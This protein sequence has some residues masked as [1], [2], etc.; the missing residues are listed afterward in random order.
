MKLYLLRHA[1]AVDIAAT[2][3]ARALTSAG[4]EEARKVGSA[5]GKLGARL[6]HIFHSPL[7]RSR[8]T[9][10]I[11]A[12]SLKFTGPVHALEELS[13]GTPT[14]QLLHAVERFPNVNE[15]LLVGHMPSITGHV[16]ELA[17]AIDISA[18]SPAGGACLE[19]PELR[20][21][22]GRLVWLKQHRDLAKHA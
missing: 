20:L 11:A 14:G 7:V 22:A 15:A 21:G 4:E 3:S 17:P 5:L 9:A 2:D 19:L 6:T 16:C 18:F 10:E 13:N 12:K 1:S 8:Q